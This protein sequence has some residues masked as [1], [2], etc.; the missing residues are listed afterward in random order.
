L[1]VI[2]KLRESPPRLLV[3]VTLPIFG[4]LLFA[5]FNAISTATHQNRSPLVTII[6]AVTALVKQSLFNS[7]TIPN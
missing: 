6:G 5:D 1:K 3:K 2:V 7:F 4:L